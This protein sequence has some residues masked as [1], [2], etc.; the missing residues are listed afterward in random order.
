MGLY[1]D[2][3]FAKSSRA[4]TMNIESDLLLPAT[5]YKD[6]FYIFS[7]QKKLKRFNSNLKLEWE[8]YL[9]TKFWKMLA[10]KF[11]KIFLLNQHNE[12]VV[13]DAKY[14]YK[15]WGPKH[16]DTKMAVIQYPVM[17][18]LSK[19]GKLKGIDFLTGQV[20]WTNNDYRWRSI[21]AVEETPKI[22]AKINK[23]E[24]YY[25]NFSN[26][27]RAQLVKADESQ[28]QFGNELLRFQGGALFYDKTTLMLKNMKSNRVEWQRQV[29]TNTQI[30]TLENMSSKFVE[31]NGQNW[32]VVKVVD[33]KKE[34]QFTLDGDQHCQ[35][36]GELFYVSH[37]LI[38]FCE[39]P[40]MV[41][42]LM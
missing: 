28:R 38:I 32:N 40:Q 14:G 3:L 34:D 20:L 24:Y 27:K 39:S 37:Q 4:V 15:I 25:M 8:I 6:N 36:I 12:M 26:G 29:T 1:P 42:K 7:N 41:I 35:H 23:D 16:L 13:Y 33:G 9:K 22:L 2:T 30:Y 19:N 11:D 10:I 17:V 18:L 21:E 31:K 5:Q